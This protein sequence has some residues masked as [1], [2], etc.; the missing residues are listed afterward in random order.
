MTQSAEKKRGVGFPVMALRD[1]VDIIVSAGQ[2]GGA[3]H[4]Q[5]AFATY[6]GHSTPTS[7]PY[8]NKLAALR[9]WGL[10]TRGGDRVIYTSLAQEFLRRAPDHMS[11]RELLVQTFLNCTAFKALYADSAM[12]VALDRGRL[13]TEAMIDIGISSESAD[14]FVDRFV[15]SAITASIGEP[16]EN[17]GV[18]LRATNWWVDFDDEEGDLSA[19]SSMV[20][21]DEQQP[22]PSLQTPDGGAPVRTKQAE[23]P[24]ALRQSWPAGDGE[25][26]FMIRSDRPIPADAFTLIGNLASQAA[27]LAAQLNQVST[28]PSYED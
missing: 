17:G 25:V 1:A 8:R 10:I 7:G 2:N 24:V 22:A 9:D 13:R 14:K 15:D 27:E 11:A 6:L 21:P 23:V 12:G 5:N 26:V 3:D 4:S 28:S 19:K 20:S 16:T 18:R